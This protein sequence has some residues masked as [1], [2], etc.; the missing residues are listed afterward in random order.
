MLHALPAKKDSSDETPDFCSAFFLAK[1][2]CLGR[3][4]ATAVQKIRLPFEFFDPF[5]F[6]SGKNH[7]VFN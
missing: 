3:V 6:C 1:L 4:L 5:L 7:S 2:I